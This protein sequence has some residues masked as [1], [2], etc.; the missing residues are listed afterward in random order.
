M[1]PAISKVIAKAWSDPQFKARLLTDPMS[2]LAAEGIAVPPGITVRLL[3]NTDQIVNFVLPRK[4]EIEELSDADLE[5][6][7][8]GAP[9]D[10]IPVNQISSSSYFGTCSGY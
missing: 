9:L 5:K 10:N 6:I 3:E 1:D 2:V 7:A 8:A 4:P